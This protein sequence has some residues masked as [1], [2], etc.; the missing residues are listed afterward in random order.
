MLPAAF[1][2]QLAFEC[3]RS[4]P[5][6]FIDAPSHGSYVGDELT[7]CRFLDVGTRPAG[8]TMLRSEEWKTRDSNSGQLS[9]WPKVDLVCV[10]ADLQP[11]QQE[12]PDA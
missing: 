10:P 6:G 3:C 8:T 4:C 1:V 11:S 12:V 9:A 7:P 2:R 5:A